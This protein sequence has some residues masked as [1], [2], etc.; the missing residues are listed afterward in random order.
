MTVFVSQDID[1]IQG[2][3]TLFEVNLSK[4]NKFFVQNR[5]VFSLHRLN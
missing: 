2:I 1:R 3:L 4:P 5:Q